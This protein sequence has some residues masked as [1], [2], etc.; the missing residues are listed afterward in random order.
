MTNDAVAPRRF[1]QITVARAVRVDSGVALQGGRVAQPFRRLESMGCQQVTDQR[2]DLGYQSRVIEPQTV[3]VDERELT[4][5]AA[6]ALAIAKHLADLVD[7]AA[8]RREQP[9][10]GVFRRGT[11]IGPCA[12]AGDSSRQGFDL[13]IAD[14]GAAQY[15]GFHFEHAAACE[16]FARGGQHRR[17]ALQSTQGC[18]RAPAHEMIPRDWPSRTT[19]PACTSRCQ[20]TRFGSNNR[21]TVDPILKRPSS[22]PFSSVVGGPGIRLTTRRAAGVMSPT[23]TVAMLPTLSAPTS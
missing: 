6:A 21:I 4:V 5:V 18:R 12:H 20:R 8:A 14:G 2:L 10:H 16:E 22:A 23:Q 9:F 11:E 17:A 15:R 1:S 7:I 13:R 3:P 19:V